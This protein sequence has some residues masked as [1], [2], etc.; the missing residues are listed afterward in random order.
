MSALGQKQPL[1]LFY[2]N[3]SERLLSGVNRT[4]DRLKFL[5]DLWAT[6]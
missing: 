5:A 3:L 1:N 2:L 4:L 6:V